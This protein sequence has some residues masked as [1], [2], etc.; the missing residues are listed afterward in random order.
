[1]SLIDIRDMSRLM[2]RDDRYPYRWP[3]ETIIRF[4]NDGIKDIFRLR[5][6]TRINAC[7]AIITYSPISMLSAFTFNEVGD[8]R[9]VASSYQGIQGWAYDTYN[10]LYFKANS[11]S[12][13]RIYATSADASVGM[14]AMATF[15]GAATGLATIKP[16]ARN[17]LVSGFGGSIQIT[18]ISTGAETW[19]VSVTASSL[20]IEDD[21]YDEALANYITSASL[22]M[23]GDDTANQQRAAAFKADYHK[24]IMGA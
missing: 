11:I 24:L 21:T 6:D 1:M 10:M 9:N 20:I 4:L 12:D 8:T 2:L 19:T 7:G 15:S 13:I 5:P 23:E 14:N 22:S 17:G 3:D 18:T 16:L